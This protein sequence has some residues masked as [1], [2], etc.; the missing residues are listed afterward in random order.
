MENQENGN[1][2]VSEEQSFT[3]ILNLFQKSR[4]DGPGPCIRS[5]GI[6]SQL[7][8]RVNPLEHCSF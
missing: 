6:K 2:T 5:M 1:F 4:K 3:D 7:T 8:P